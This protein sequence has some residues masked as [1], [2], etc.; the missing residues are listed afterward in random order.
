MLGFDSAT[1]ER[2]VHYL[3]RYPAKLHPPVVNELIRAYSKLGDTVLDPFCGSGTVL[4]EATVLGR[5]GIGADIDP[6][7]VFVTKIKLHKYNVQHLRKTAELILDKVAHWRRSASEY[8]RLKFSDIPEELVPT[9]AKE[10]NLW[11]PP[12]PNLFHWFRNYVI[13]DLARILREIRVLKAPSTHKDFLLLC[14]ASITRSSSNADPVPVSGLEV[15]AHMRRLDERGRV[16]D[17][18]EH[19]KKAIYNA[20]KDVESYAGRRVP[21]VSTTARQIDVTRISKSI[22]TPIDLILTSPPYNNAVDYY[23]RHQ[24]EM[25]WLSLTKTRNERIQL[26]HRY[27]G[28]PRVRTREEIADGVELPSLAKVWYEKMQVDSTSRAKDFEHYVAS[29]QKAFQQQAGLLDTGQRAIFVIGHSN[30]RGQEIPTKDLLVEL[31]KSWFKVEE[32]LWYPLKNRYMSYS[33]HNGASID[34]EYVLVLRRNSL[35]V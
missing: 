4:V 28:R 29:M 9:I 32:L 10:D 8:E 2:L 12:I 34:K 23:R 27:I 22:R 6:L 18:F 30:W 5:H 17:P 14:F 33:R 1:R 3:F 21:G 16:I 20:L 7:A 15:T 13:I 19:F 31:A 11:I 24:L 35:G 25:F 26:K